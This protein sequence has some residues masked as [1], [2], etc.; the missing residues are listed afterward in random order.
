MLQ[1]GA[2]KLGKDGKPKICMQYNCLLLFHR[3]LNRILTYFGDN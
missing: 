1:R 2:P 3:N